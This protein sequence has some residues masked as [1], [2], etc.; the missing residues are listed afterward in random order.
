MLSM[1]PIF[2]DTFF[3]SGR[4][5]LLGIREAPGTGGFFGWGTCLGTGGL[6]MRESRGAGV[7]SVAGVAGALDAFAG[8]FFIE[9][10]T[11]ARGLREIYKI[12]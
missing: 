6:V 2:E 12:I 9:G 10:L 8:V 4:G 5:V 3:R 7:R 11:L 1:E